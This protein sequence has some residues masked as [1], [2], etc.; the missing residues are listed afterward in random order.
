MKI[1]FLVYPSLLLLLCMRLSAYQDNHQ[2]Q[3]LVT[4]QGVVS[5]IYGN[6]L[7]NAEVRLANISSLPVS[8]DANGCYLIQRGI[9]GSGIIILRINKPG[10]RTMEKTNIIAHIGSNLSFVFD[11][12]M[13][14]IP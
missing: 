7:P 6:P 4:V 8:T 9:T 14:E 11:C 13:T 12:E 2:P 1:R 5:D 3:F 10:Y